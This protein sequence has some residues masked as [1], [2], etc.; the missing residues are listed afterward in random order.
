MGKLI[1]FP[2]SLQ[3][4]KRVN[5]NLSYERALKVALA[6]KDSKEVQRKSRMI[7]TE[8][9]KFLADLQRLIK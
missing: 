5:Q 3:M 6:L 7:K 2:M 8:A 4:V 1:Q 9:D